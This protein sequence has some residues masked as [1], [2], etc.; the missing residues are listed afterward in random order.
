VSVVHWRHVTSIVVVANEIG[1]RWIIVRHLSTLIG[2]AEM[3]TIM[4]IN[5]NCVII[6]DTDTNA[7]FSLFLYSHCC[8]LLVLQSLLALPPKTSSLSLSLMS[9]V[10]AP[11]LPKLSSIFLYLSSSVATPTDD[12]GVAYLVVC[13]HL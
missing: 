11:T 10:N 5:I 12:D 7:N 4:Q 8:M 6:L 3:T 13:M 2:C 1:R 9:H